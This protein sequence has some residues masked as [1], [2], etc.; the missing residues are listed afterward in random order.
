MFVIYFQKEVPNPEIQKF[1]FNEE[2]LAIYK[3]VVQY[4]KSM[5]DETNQNSLFASL[6]SS[7]SE[8]SSQNCQG[9]SGNS[10]VNILNKNVIQ[11]LNALVREKQNLEGCILVQRDCVW[12][13]RLR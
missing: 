11:N 12:E 8:K 1:I 7:S 3:L 10:S 5:P 6:T 13:C 9:R 2:V 4:P